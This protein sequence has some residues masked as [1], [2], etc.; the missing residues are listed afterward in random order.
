MVL[1]LF[2]NIFRT[3][4][5]KKKETEIEGRILN[6]QD[7][8]HSIKSYIL[9]V[10]FKCLLGQNNHRRRPKLILFLM[11]KNFWYP[12]KTCWIVKNTEMNEIDPQNKL[13]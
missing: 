3:Y 6:T 11:N 2:I 10:R 5:Q 9:L 4:F 7:P 13:D 8:L 1:L 12:L